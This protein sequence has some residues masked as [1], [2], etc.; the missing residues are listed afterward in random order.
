MA[1]RDRQ[2]D[3]LLAVKPVVRIL[4]RTLLLER[5]FPA[6]FQ[7]PRHQSILR[8]D[9][10][11]LTFG[12]LGLIGGAVQVLPQL[13][14]LPSALPARVFEGTQAEVQRCRR[15]RLEYLSSDDLIE[16]PRRQAAAD[17]VADRDAPP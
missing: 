11:V 12:T 14:L 17:F 13:F 3:R 5:C 6:L 8:L 10:L 9:R 7:G 4:G 16:G 1:L 2:L 15:E